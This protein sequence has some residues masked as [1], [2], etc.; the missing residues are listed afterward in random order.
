ME[1]PTVNTVNDSA[2]GN[3]MGPIWKITLS[4]M[5][6]TA[7]IG[8]AIHL[9]ALNTRHDENMQQVAKVEFR[10]KQ[11]AAYRDIY[12]K[13]GKAAADASISTK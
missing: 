3:F 8:F 6:G 13:E 5:L 7:C 10:T 12:M 4:T 1:A 2:S 11:Y 9:F